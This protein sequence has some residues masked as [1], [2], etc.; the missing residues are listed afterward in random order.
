MAMGSDY[1]K[2]E[3]RA[4]QICLIPLMI[5][6]AIEFSRMLGLQLQT[7]LLGFRAVDSTE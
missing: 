7:Y 4:S 6:N 1:K 2:R 5:R 3:E